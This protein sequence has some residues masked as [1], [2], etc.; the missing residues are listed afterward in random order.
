MTGSGTCRDVC[1]E[2][3]IPCFSGD[4]R[5]GFDACNPDSYPQGQ[6]DFV[7]L[8]P[9][10]WRM[11]KYGPDPR[12]LSN[13]PNAEAFY[14]RLRLLLST[15]KQKLSEGGKLA[16]LMG[17]YFDVAERRM[18]PCTHM[19]KEICLS[20]GLWPACT[21]IIRFQHNNSSSQ[22]SYARSFIPG[23]HDTCLVMEKQK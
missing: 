20:I 15:G 21:D 2:L 19:T 16:V 5:S 23:L 17:D 9:P 4:I 7:W 22:K 18:I 10:Y 14:R 6:Y 12:C 3:G 11:K 8:H 1:R 13:C